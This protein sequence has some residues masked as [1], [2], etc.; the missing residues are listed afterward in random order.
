[1]IGWD[2]FARAAGAGG[3]AGPAA[4]HRDRLLRRGNR[5]GT[6][7]GRAHPG[8]DR[9]QRRGGDR[10]DL[11]GAGPP[12]GV[13]ADRRRRAGGAVRDGPGHHRRHPS[14]RLRGRHFRLPGRGDVR[15]GGGAGGPLGEGQG[16]AGRRRR[17]GML[18]RTTWRSS[19]GWSRSRAIPPRP[20]RWARSR[21]CPTRCGTPSTRRPRPRPNSPGR[22][23][24][25]VPPV[26]EGEEPGLE[27]RDY[28][29]PPRSTFASGMHAA[30]VE[31]DPDTSEIT[32][33]KY[34]V[35]HDCGTLI[36]PM[37]VTGQVHGGVAQGIAGALY[38][39]LA[40]DEHGQLLNASFMDFLMPYV[41]ELPDRSRT[42]SPGD[43]VAAEPVGHQGCRRGRGDP[44][45]RGDRLRRRGRDGVPDRLRCRSVPSLLFDLR[46][47]HGRSTT[48]AKVGTMKISG[49]S[50]L[51]AP[52]ERVWA[53]IT[54]PAVLA[55]GH[56]RL[57]RPDTDRGEPVRAHRHP[58]RGLDQGLLLRRSLLLRPARNPVR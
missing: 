18:S 31:I 33:E 6:V 47:A 28:Y 14:F 17:A 46:R 53:A 25:N 43:P 42:R 27:S 51:H 7:R 3:R 54:D 15:V 58:R 21:C 30:I 4:G 12:D 44:G 57:R 56:P 40:Y 20:S 23:I 52:P 19:T 26:A 38:E 1:M 22:P 36:N 29:S 55:G 9:R 8:A 39:T 48:T 11:A 24:P 45:V 41:T 37:I 49:S 2:D 50:V 35:V 13:R 32:I 16:A 34:C 10:A 5:P